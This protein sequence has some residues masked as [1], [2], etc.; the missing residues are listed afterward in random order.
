MTGGDGIVG[1]LLSPIDPQAIHAVGS[2]ISWHA[3]LMVLGW[4]IIAPL[5]ILAARF[6][7]ILPSQDWPRELDSPYWWRAHWM[8]QTAVA[9]LT[10]IAF[11]LAY[12]AENTGVAAQPHRSLGYILIVL[13][14]LQILS[15]F[16]RGSKGGPTAPQ[17][18]G[19]LFGDH[20]NMTPRRLV[21]EFFHKINGYALIGL[22]VAVVLAGLSAANAPRWMWLI[23]GI[24]W[25]A[26][27]LIFVLLQVKRGAADTYQAIWGADPDLPGNKM[28]KRGL[29]TYRPGDRDQE[30]K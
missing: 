6:F 23:L 8:G 27:A 29:G 24:W 14:V 15:G 12:A 21:F 1:W 13:L 20:F 11:G 5:S 10:V 2:S 30:R 9:V 26:L 7:K 16:L 3:R 22:S 17:P 28:K 4:G 19:S 18:D 25:T